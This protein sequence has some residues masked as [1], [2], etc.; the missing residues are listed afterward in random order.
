[1]LQVLANQLAGYEMGIKAE[2]GSW[3]YCLLDCFKSKV[4]LAV[5][6]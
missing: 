3:V 4:S 6:S 1:M 2:S 5:A